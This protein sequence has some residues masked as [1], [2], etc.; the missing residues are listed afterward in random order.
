M[1]HGASIGR[2]AENDFLCYANSVSNLENGVYISVGSAVMSPMIFE[3]SLSMAQNMEI[4]NGS[5]IDNHYILVVDFGRIG[6]G[7]GTKTAN[8]QWIIQPITC[9]T[10]KRFIAWAVKCTT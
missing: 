10:A 9:V 1:N 6:L 4:Q 3:K 2:T 8:H 7:T 5:H